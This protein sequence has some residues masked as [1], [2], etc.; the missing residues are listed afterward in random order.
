MEILASWWPIS[1]RLPTVQ[2]VSTDASEFLSAMITCW[3]AAMLELVLLGP[4]GV[5]ERRYVSAWQSP[6]LEQHLNL[7]TWKSHIK[8]IRSMYHAP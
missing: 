2:Y 5:Q 7:F 8:Y 4:Q 1:I 3:G 6:R